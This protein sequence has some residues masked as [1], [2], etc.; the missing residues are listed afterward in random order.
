[1]KA[2]VLC[3][4]YGVRLGEHTR[5]TPKPMLRLGERPL[6]EYIL[7]HLVQ[8]GFEEIALNLHFLPEAIRGYFGDGSRCACRLTYS[9]ESELL[10]TAGGVRKLA[11]FL[12]GDDFLVHYGD[13]VTNQ[14]FTAMLEFHRRR[15]ALAT[16]LVHRRAR[17]N[18]VVVLDDQRRVTGFLERPTE[19]ERPKAE[20]SWVFSGVTIGSPELLDRLPPT[21]PS[22]LP[23][24]VFPALASTGRL[25]A[26]PLSGDRCAVDSPE[27][28]AEVRAAAE[29]G[30]FG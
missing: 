11:R 17:S 8:H 29:R 14:D 15:R 2:V 26:F 5:E 19:E 16:L 7:R 30:L 9:D 22:D 1:M 4:G 27:R 25:F 21:V 3:A 10:G 13:V 23:R 28:L 24:D 6:L 12:A 18:S 20:S